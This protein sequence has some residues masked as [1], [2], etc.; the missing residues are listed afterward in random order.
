[1]ANQGSRCTTY[2][3]VTAEK[4]FVVP[5]PLF[6][7]TPRPQLPNR[8]QDAQGSSKTEFKPVN[9]AKRT[10]NFSD[11][12]GAPVGK[13]P[14]YRKS[15]SWEPS[16]RRGCI[17][18]GVRS[19]ISRKQSK[20]HI[21][22]TLPFTQKYSPILKL[23]A[24]QT[25]LLAK[26]E[27]NEETLVAICSYAAEHKRIQL[28]SILSIHH[29]HILQPLE[30]FQ[31]DG[32]FVVVTP[33]IRHSLADILLLSTCLTE[34]QIRTIA[35]A[36]LSALQ[37]LMEKGYTH[38]DVGL[39]SILVARDGRIL[40]AGLEN[41]SA[42]N[43]GL[44]PSLGA[45]GL[46]LALL[47]TLNWEKTFPFG[48]SRR[49]MVKMIRDHPTSYIK[50]PSKWSQELLSFME[51]LFLES[52]LEGKTLPTQVRLSRYDRTQIDTPQHPFLEGKTTNLSTLVE[53]ASIQCQTVWNI[54][55]KL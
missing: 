34:S 21:I 43:D 27:N 37:Y 31:Q 10:A 51:R 42:E 40:L 41:I 8:Y 36:V 9:S 50:E 23:S 46:G 4:S 13:K 3:G 55:E 38:G 11:L 53:I 24:A 22:Q 14:I 48:L 12:A 33:F 49:E 47:D 5:P 35:L 52:K 30:A 28:S 26:S 39:S 29:E 20:N 1:M 6:K 54:P 45:T 25:V 2:G 7:R 44:E 18:T 17:D 32:E 16:L 15:N 19:E